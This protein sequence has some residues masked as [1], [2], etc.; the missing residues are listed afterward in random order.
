MS[1]EAGGAYSNLQLLYYYIS[2]ERNISLTAKKAHM[3]RNSIIYRL[4]KIQ[5]MLEIDLDDPDVRLR[6]MI[7][8]KILEM[9]GRLRLDGEAKI[10]PVSSSAEK[11]RLME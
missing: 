4:R 9:S 11:I 5:D 6:L 8:F 7:S 2:S 1:G 3:H 10:T